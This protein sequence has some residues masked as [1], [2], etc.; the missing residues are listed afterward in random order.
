DDAMAALG[1]VSPL[2]RSGRIGDALSRLAA[3][4]AGAGGDARLLQHLGEHY[5]HCGKPDA[6]A[7]CY[8]RAAELTPD[9]PRCLYNLSAALIALGR[10]GEAEALLD[11][12][13]ALDQQDADAWQN[14]STLRRQTPESNHVA[15]LFKAVERVRSGPAEVA[16]CYA[17][18]KELEDLGDPDH[19]FAWLRRG[20]DRRRSL[21]SYRVEADVAAMA[22]ITRVFDAPLFDPPPAGCPEPGPVFVMGLPRSGT[23]LV[24][25]I[26]SSHSDVESLGEI[27]DFALALMRLAGATG[28]KGDLIRRSADLD[29][30]ALGRAY[31]DSVA[32]YGR[33]RPMFI[34]KTP[35]NFLYVGL[36]ARALP[37]A[38]II[39][40]RRHPLDSGYALYKTLFRMGCPYSYD[41]GDLAAYM[42][43]HRRL[44]DHWRAVAPGG[45]LDV[46]YEALVADQEAVSRRII[47]H[48]GLDWQDACLTFHE[49]TAPA[50]TASAAQVRQPIHAR[51]VGLWRRYADQ[52]EPLAAALRAGGVDPAELV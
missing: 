36:I 40:L 21:L 1:G 12:V 27:N 39:H 4:E 25:R 43:A 15:D 30:A 37:N 22:E 33:T 32:G 13:I 29:P 23:T 31:L 14:R 35:A 44:M 52:L 48:C 16:L 38:R 28:G 49:N 18:A 8:R 26:I 45:I 10:L 20:A 2:I 47:D 9:D 51:S 7:R 46:D 50:A 24:D 19:S 34:D 11:R 6:A 3:I 41:L 5:T 17:L 42:L